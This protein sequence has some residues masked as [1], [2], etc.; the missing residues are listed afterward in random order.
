MSKVRQNSRGNNNEMNTR[1]SC[2]C[3]IYSY[4]RIKL[5]QKINGLNHGMKYMDWMLWASIKYIPFNLNPGW[6]RSDEC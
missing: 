5:G 6:V 3:K 2:W 1:R 4:I